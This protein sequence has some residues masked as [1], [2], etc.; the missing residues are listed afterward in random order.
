[1]DV[2]VDV[3]LGDVWAVLGAGIAL[4]GL[5]GMGE[6]LH[7]LGLRAV[8]VRRWVHVGVGLFMVATPF[9]FSS[10]GPMY[11]LATLF[12]IG[13]ALAR[14]RAWWPGV[15]GGRPASI[16]TVTFPL[17]VFPAL[18]LGWTAEAPRPWTVQ[19]AFLILAVADPLAAWVGERI[20]RPHPVGYGQKSWAGSLAFM[21]SA[22]V[23]C[24][25]VLHL[26][27]V[28]SAG[29]VVALSLVVAVSTTAA[30]ALGGRGWDNFFVVC[31]A[32]VPLVVWAT[33]PTRLYA[34]GGGVVAGGLFAALTWRVRWLSRSGALA[35]GGLAA[36]LIG[37]G[38]WAWAVPAFVFFVLSSA[39]SGVGRRRKQAVAAR[40]EKGTVRDAG[41]VYANGGIGWGLLVLYAVG[42]DPV[43]LYGAFCGA[44]AAAAADTWATEIGALAPGRP[45][46]IT[47]G[48]PVPP[49]TSGAVTAWGTIAAVAGAASVATSAVAV[50]QGLM[51][52]A[53]AGASLAIITAA[54]TLGACADSVV[55]ATL[56]AQYRDAEGVT[57]RPVG[58][59]VRGWSW[60]T[61]D[62]VNLVCT[63]TGALL[64]GLGGW[65]LAA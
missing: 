43:V 61:N 60:M 62:R 44:F 50:A 2:L 34:L 45:R 22:A 29:E 33:E 27:E 58:P 1:M 53:A 8:A 49:G 55:G 51:G 16:G 39:L 38:G 19:A 32:V 42:G 10:P 24:A 18:W 54:G 3:T 36:T 26:A 20:G 25:L 23:A 40:A 17:A 64:G 59:R 37:L 13:N 6:G 11:G 7:R 46:L 41:Q 9:V 56:Q 5:V 52:P 47:T 15:H 12:A 14:W 28:A 35:G 4:L 48:R 63:A 21:S 57:E 65:M 30:E 31:A